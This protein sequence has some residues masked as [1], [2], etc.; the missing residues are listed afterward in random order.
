ML[1]R[2]ESAFV[3]SNGRLVLFDHTNGLVEFDSL[4]HYVREIGELGNEPGTYSR[5]GGFS[6]LPNG[7]AVVWD[8]SSARL[9]RYAAG[10]AAASVWVRDRDLVAVRANATASYGIRVPPG[11]HAG[12]QV[13]GSIGK[14][15]LETGR[16]VDDGTPVFALTT[17]ESSNPGMAQTF[18]SLYWLAPVWAVSRKQ[19]VF[20]VPPPGDRDSS[21]R[22][23][24]YTSAGQPDVLITGRLPLPVRPVTQSDIHMRVKAAYAQLFSRGSYARDSAGCNNVQPDQSTTAPVMC[25]TM[26]YIERTRVPKII[27]PIADII[28]L[29]DDGFWLKTTS[30][31]GESRTWL[32]ADSTGQLVGQ[33]LLKESER[34]LGGS[35]NRIFVAEDSPGS[36]LVTARTLV[37]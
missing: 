9:N 16:F 11:K 32:L 33:L 7:T 37:H 20:Y 25:A 36:L 34:I 31:D 14:I 18:S 28:A 15:S 24:E 21:I 10:S 22:I 26:R 35:S 12:D 5:V 2:P 30:T 17:R 29:D 3:G 4:A 19:R 1:M 13:V 6:E 23:E 8:F 27:P